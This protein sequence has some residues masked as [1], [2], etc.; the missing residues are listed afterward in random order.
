MI[1][2]L[3][4]LGLCHGAVLQFFF[5]I[6]IE[7]S[8][9]TSEGHGRT[10]LFFYHTEITEV[11]PLYRLGEIS[12]CTGD[13]KAVALRHLRQLV[14][15]LDLLGDLFSLLD[16]LNVHDIRQDLILRLSLLGDQES[17][18]IERDTAVVADDT[19]SA[20]SVRKTGQDTAV[21]RTLHLRCVSIE[22][23]VVMCFSILEY[24]LNFRIH[25]AAI[26]LQRC[27]D[28][29]DTAKWHDRAL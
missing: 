16:R 18:A 19:S 26:S 13:V 7:E 9:H 21:T 14:K 28:H 29:A 5:R 6:N 15:A 4:D 20:V 27:S 23:A 22:N 25:L 3:L 24:F 17:R 11:Q 8:G 1:D 10:V 12:R 2:D